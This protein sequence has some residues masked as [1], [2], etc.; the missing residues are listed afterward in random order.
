MYKKKEKSME[1]LDDLISNAMEISDV[2][3]LQKILD[4][5][6]IKYDKEITKF[7]DLKRDARARCSNEKMDDVLKEF[8]SYKAQS[9]DVVKN[10]DVNNMNKFRAEQAIKTVGRTASPIAQTLMK[11]ALTIAMY[12]GLYLMPL[13]LKVGIAGG[14]FVTKRVPRMYR[15]AKKGLESMRNGGLKKVPKKVLA[16]VIAGGIGAEAV[17]LLNYLAKGS[18]PGKILNALPGIKS[19][20]KLAPSIN[21]RKT[22]LLTTGIVKGVDA[23]RLKNKENKMFEPI[24]KGFFLAKGMKV[25]EEISDFSDIKSYV[26]KLDDQ[27]RYEFDQYLKKCISMKKMINNKDSK[28]KKVGKSVLKLVSDSFEMAS[29]LALVTPATIGA[30]KNGNRD[31]DGGQAEPEPA[32]A[33]AGENAGEKVHQGQV[34]TAG[35]RVP[36]GAEQ[37]QP[38]VVG[39]GVETGATDGAHGSISYQQLRPEV[40]GK[41]GSVQLFNND[42]IVPG[43]AFEITPETTSNEAVKRAAEA[44]DNYAKNAQ[45]PKTV[46]KPTEPVH[47]PE[48]VAVPERPRVPKTVIKPTEPV[49]VPEAVAAPE[50]PRVPEV[51]TV[52]EA[53]AIPEIEMTPE[54]MVDISRKF[55]KASPSKWESFL[56]YCAEH[57]NEITAGTV[58]G[59]IGAA[60]LYFM[61]NSGWVLAF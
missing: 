4:Q 58:I 60:F 29:Y 33:T 34:A 45:V 21:V 47:V 17:F 15:G 53:V 52:P 56:E 10:L 41:S 19:C 42:S 5:K 22:V 23:Y 8:D 20:L 1:K 36:S 31:G 37:V 28:V 49:H 11:S 40:I 35:E 51:T 59:G 7:D 39:S 3:T 16:A 54:E 25:D 18:V 43:D 50:M 46:I 2:I 26:D 30:G 38:E 61:E 24:I 14:V 9:L 6:N 32:R 12:Q 27:G 44:I 55:A 48:A 57:K 13:P